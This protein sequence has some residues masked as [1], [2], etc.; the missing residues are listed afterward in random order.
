MVVPVNRQRHAHDGEHRRDEQRAGTGDDEHRE[1]REDGQ[2][3]ETPDD[4]ARTDGHRKE[5]AVVGDGTDGADEAVEHLCVAGHPAFALAPPVFDVVCGVDAGGGIE[6][7]RDVQPVAV[8]LIREVEVL[9]EHVFVV[10]ADGFERLA[11][12]DDGAGGSHLEVREDVENPSG[13]VAQENRFVV[14]ER[15]HEA[16]RF[17]DGASL[18]D[19][20]LLEFGNGEREEV[21]VDDFVGVV[22]GDVLAV[23]L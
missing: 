5:V 19:I 15:F 23:G 10:A 22:N 4:R 8:T 13:D 6:Q 14:G 2:H 16:V 1:L 17:G 3:Q 18:D 12:N 21:L 7:L 11:A 9:G 20:G